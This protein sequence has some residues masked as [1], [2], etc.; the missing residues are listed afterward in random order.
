MVRERWAAIDA[1]PPWPVVLA[2]REAE[3]EEE[4]R[5]DSESFFLV[6]DE[7]SWEM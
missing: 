3:L 5:L 4:W 7:G 2:R 6:C 1:V